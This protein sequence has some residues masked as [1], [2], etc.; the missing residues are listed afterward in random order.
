[1]S[2]LRQVFNRGLL[3][4]ASTLFSL[5]AFAVREYNLP[6]PAS[7]ITREIY[8]L[9]MLTAWVATAIMII[10][11]GIILYALINFRKSKGYQPDMEFNH[12]WFGR[13][14]WALVPAIVLGIDF[15]IAGSATETLGNI[16]SHDPADVTVK[17]TGMSPTV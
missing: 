8:D 9:H 1:M 15:S 2:K 10:V 16:E 17:V 11:T 7:T 12:T 13:W 3:L 5:P 14:S 4:I 6:E